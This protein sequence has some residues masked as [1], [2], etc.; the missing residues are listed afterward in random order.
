MGRGGREKMGIRGKGRGARQRK[1]LK[2]KE[3]K[4]GQAG[5]EGKE[6][7]RDRKRGKTNKVKNKILECTIAG[8]ENK[9]KDFW[10]ELE[11]WQVIVMREIWLDEKR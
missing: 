4:E 7:E 2:E 11:E 8:L 6:G 1:V 3:K 9:N 10:R 5:G